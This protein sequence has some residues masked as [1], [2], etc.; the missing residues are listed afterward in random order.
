[1]RFSHVQD[2]AWDELGLDWYTVGVRLDRLHKADPEGGDT[3]DNIW[4]RP[5]AP[6]AQ[7]S[8]PLSN[9]RGA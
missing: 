7:P 6:Q 5:A 1:M 9:A 2:V 3:W 4:V 8:S